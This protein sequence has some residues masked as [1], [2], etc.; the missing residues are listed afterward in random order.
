MFEKEK[1]KGLP[2]R[3]LL[4]L[5][6]GIVIGVAGM[7]L[8]MMI[9]NRAMPRPA[10]P[11]SLPVVPTPDIRYTGTAAAQTVPMADFTKE[12][13]HTF[14][15]DEEQGLMAIS[16]RAMSHESHSY[17]S[18]LQVR[19]WT[20]E[21]S[22]NPWVTLE[23][24]TAEYTRLS[25][26]PNQSSLMAEAPDQ[27]QVTTFDL[28]TQ[29]SKSLIPMY[30]ALYSP[31]NQWLATQFSSTIS[32]SHLSSETPTSTLKTQGSPRSFTFSPDSKMIAVA[33][34]DNADSNKAYVEVF[35]LP[36]LTPVKSYTF[37]GVISSPL[38][39]SPDNIHMAFGIDNSIRVI[40]LQ[41]DEQRYFDLFKPIQHLAI[42]PTGEWLAVVGGET[43]TDG[44]KLVTFYNLAESE[45]LAPTLVM[46]QTTRMNDDVVGI[47]FVEEGILVGEAWGNITLYRWNGTVWGDPVMVVE[48][49]K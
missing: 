9:A 40:S 17:I 37:E 30:Q 38:V 1:R 11:T 19:P 7:A 25:F 2:T 8:V 34:I 27:L 31:D 12:R 49:F 43:N 29:Q 46:T 24:S 36:D 14:A 28:T 4:Y 5:V 21:D 47:Q 13:L 32:L 20:L 16:L 39:F 48:N 42:D 3:G 45:T 10:E 18:F 44:D 22:D 33:S 15:V 23:R 35:A 6:A 26:A 41:D